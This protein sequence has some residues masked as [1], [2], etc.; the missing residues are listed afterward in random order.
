MSEFETFCEIVIREE[1]GY[2]DHPADDGGATK[3]GISIGFLRLIDPGVTKADIQDLTIDGARAIYREHFWR[4]IRGDDLPPAL[5]LLVFDMAVNS[6]VSDAAKAL[7]ASVGALE[8]GI[9]G[10]QTVA[11]SN[12]TMLHPALIYMTTARIL[13]FAKLDDFPV[14][15][16]GWVARAL[17]LNNLAQEMNRG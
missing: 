10:S 16:R 12:G 1:G 5:A 15:G 7:Q 17:R 11:A 13:H 9:I 14:F 4:P 8:D 6:G 2:S 3:Y